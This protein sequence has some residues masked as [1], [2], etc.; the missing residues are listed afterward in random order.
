MRFIPGRVLFFSIIMLIKVLFIRSEI[1]P[2]HSQFPAVFLEFASLI[3]I[4]GLLDIFTSRKNLLLFLVVD[5]LLTLYLISTVMYFDHF[6]RLLDYS[7][8]SQIPLITEIN[9]SIADLF[10][11]LYLLFFADIIILGKAR[12]LFNHSYKRISLKLP[13]ASLIIIML[14]VKIYSSPENILHFAQRVG[15]LNTQVYQ[16]VISL[17]TKSSHPV[18]TGSL[19]IASIQRI[20]QIKPMPWPRYFGAAKDMNLILVQLES[21]ENFVLGLSINGQELTPNLNRLIK[22]S[23]YFPYFY[24][25]VAQGNTSDAEFIT[26]T[27]LYPLPRG[28]VSKSPLGT[29]I[30]SLPRILRSQGYTAITFHANDVSFWRRD[31]LYNYLGFDKYYDE[32]YYQD[33]DKVGRWG[34]SDEVLFKKAVPILLHLKNNNQKFYVSLITLSS[35]HPY[36]LP[37]QKKLLQLPSGL[38][39]TVLGD[40]LTA[41]NYQDYSLGLFIQDL[42]DTGLWNESMIVVYGDHFGL[43]KQHS[44]ESQPFLTSI[45][46]R[47]YD[48]LDS[49]NVPLIIRVP[50]INPNVVRNVGGQVDIFQTVANLLGIHVDDYLLFGQDILNH[51]SN[52]L[53]FRYYYPEGTFIS[54]NVFYI[55]GENTGLRIDTH[56]PIYNEDLF[57][58]EELRIKSLIELSDLY[59]EKL[60]ME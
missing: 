21:A 53:G 31:N 52:I 12:V 48:I 36:N 37:N 7:I 58:K 54:A 20:K 8:I 26:N 40:Y 49:I 56:E 28:A 23:L 47:K 27:S 2:L 29:D 24:S 32:A 17:K 15:I 34:S 6:G 3:I 39:N 50:G 13:I 44:S 42:K 11:F 51:D 9:D 14:S 33:E 60:K 16:A 1:Y 45:I 41:V 35:H 18:P 22:E 38:K 10:S 57:I 43:S 46:G 19:T 55:P 25:Q 4:F 5:F 59:L 30:P